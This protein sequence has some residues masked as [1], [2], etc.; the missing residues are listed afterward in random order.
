[1]VAFALASFAVLLIAWI[2][3]PDQPRSTAHMDPAPPE[4]EP[5]AA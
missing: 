2:V 3:A 4:V 5:A 1:M